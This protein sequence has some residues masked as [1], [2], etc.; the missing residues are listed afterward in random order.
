MKK[1][2]ITGKQANNGYKISFSNRKTRKL[3]HVNLQSKKLWDKK[4]KKWKKV[5][6][7]TKALKSL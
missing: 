6:V 3:Q 4:E 5:L 1:C 7:S 2:A